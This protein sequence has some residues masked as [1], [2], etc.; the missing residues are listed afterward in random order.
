MPESRVVAGVLWA[1][2]KPDVLSLLVVNK[3]GIIETRQKR[4]GTPPST[5][6]AL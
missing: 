2:A 3:H 1:T 6:A 5:R 4:S